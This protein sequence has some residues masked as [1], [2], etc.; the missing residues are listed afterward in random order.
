MSRRVLRGRDPQIG[1]GFHGL[2]MESVT[3]HATKLFGHNVRL[4]LTEPCRSPTPTSRQP[5]PS[6]WLFPITQIR[7]GA[8]ARRLAVRV[9]DRM[10]LSS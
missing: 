10:A 4:F 1:D 7:S 5:H 9:F 8:A 2:S 6:A 3:F